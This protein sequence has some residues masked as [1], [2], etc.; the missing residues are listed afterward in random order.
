MMQ[1]RL[2]QHIWFVM[3]RWQLPQI[4]PSDRLGEGC[5]VSV[6]CR[7]SRLRELASPIG[8]CLEGFFSG[9]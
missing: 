6:A 1:V 3:K 9:L 4:H 2:L 5:S 8:G 7:F